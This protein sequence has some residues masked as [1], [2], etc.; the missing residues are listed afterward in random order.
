MNLLRQWKRSSLLGFTKRL[1]R[2]IFGQKC[3]YMNCRGRLRYKGKY[4]VGSSINSS[5][6]EH[7]ECDKCDA[8]LGDIY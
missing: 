5:V 4:R 3:G 6:M 2:Y 7:W 1:S 8:T